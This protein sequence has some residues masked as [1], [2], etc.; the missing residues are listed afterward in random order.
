MSATTHSPSTQE[1]N[2][3]IASIYSSRAE[4]VSHIREFLETNGC[5][6][7]VN[8]TLT[9]IPDYTIVCGDSDFVKSIYSNTRISGRKSLIILWSVKNSEID[10]FRNLATKVIVTDKPPFTDLIVKQIFH[11]FFTSYE[12]IKNI[13]TLQIEE[14]LEETV[15]KPEQEAY[16]LPV[17]DVTPK[18]FAS[19]RATEEIPVQEEALGQQDKKRISDTLASVFA[20]EKIKTEK[21]KMSKKRRKTISPKTLI[22]FLILLL[23]SPTVWYLFSLT[24]SVVTLLF[25]A[26][27][28]SEGKLQTSQQF[29]TVSSY[30][31]NQAKGSLTIVGTV[32]RLTNTSYI[33]RRQE[34]VLSFLTDAGDAIHSAQD[35]VIAGKEFSKTIASQLYGTQEVG[36]SPAQLVGTMKIQLPY[37]H[38][39]LGLASSELSTLTREGAF[40]FSIPWVS[41]KA[42]S[43]QRVLDTART[44]ISVIEGLLS[45]YSSAGGFDARRTYLLLLQNSMELRPTGGFIGSI[46]KVTVHEGIIESL[47]IQDVYTVDGQLKGHV[48]PPKAIQELLGQEHWYLRDSNWNPDF[49]VSGQTAAWFYEKETGTKVDGV[50]AIS[51]P[52]LTDLLKVTGPIDLPDYNDRITA[53]NFFGK[54][55]YYVQHDFFPGSTQKK[56][57]LGN[58]TSAILTRVM[59]DKSVNAVSLFSAIQAGLDRHDIQMVF[60][61][62]SLN[63]LISHQ[64]WSGKGVTQRSCQVSSV[65]TCIGDFMNVVEANVSV[66]KVNAFITRKRTTEESLDS[67]GLVTSTASI[68]YE[69]TSDEATGGGGN[70]KNFMRFILPT[71]SSLIDVSIDG[72]PIPVR[73]EKAKTLPTAPYMEK[74]EQT[75]EQDGSQT[76]SLSVVFDVPPK[77]IRNFV[78]RYSHQIP[79]MQSGQTTLYEFVQPKQ[80]GISKTVLETRI[81]FPAEFTLVP[82]KEPSRR[83]SVANQTQL[84]YNSLLTQD[85][86]IR[87]L[88]TKP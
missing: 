28:L 23:I 35:V 64:G 18:Y 30:W 77:Q 34:R 76:T 1:E 2:A 60:T 70:Y 47:D 84:E 85:E 50:I 26:L 25:S 24:V 87:V 75:T 51:S 37:I 78:V 56:D 39:R 40:P 11:F 8:E 62:A 80:P 49:T 72:K 17:D 69:N 5:S 32:F 43:T 65:N 59:Q 6:V 55:L 36:V 42:V 82:Q 33:L 22:G 27:Q 63:K 19:S 86:I 48:D 44:N 73:S 20:N 88:M 53:E 16:E 68:L 9:T 14:E 66:N 45:V 81:R 31:T 3:S 7:F 52:F 74:I 57:F 58:L 21:P 67:D 13:S 61:D 79:Q 29:V 12:P 38:D 4:D 10:G 41:A 83:V 54:S 15:E 46:A 71:A